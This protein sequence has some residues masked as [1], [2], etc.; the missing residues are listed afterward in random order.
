[1]FDG[2]DPKD[3]ENWYRR[4]FESD[5]YEDF[6]LEALGPQLSSEQVSRILYW[7]EVRPPASI[8]DLSCGAG[9]HT[10]ELARRGF[11]A[12][13][14]DLSPYQLAKARSRSAVP[15]GTPNRPGGQADFVRGDMRSIPL[16]DRSVQAVVCL[17]N[18]FGYFSD[19]G[20]SSVL[21]EVRRVLA[22]GG[23]LV[24]DVLNR[25][26]FLLH[27]PERT[28]DRVADGLVLQDL[29]YQVRSG[30]LQTS[31]TY[32]RD[33]GCRDTLITLNRLYSAHELIA[34]CEAAGL[35]VLDFNDGQ[36]RG[37]FNWRNSHGLGVVARRSDP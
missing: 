37:Y 1:M 35:E 7:L 14:L 36:L 32:I 18:S 3:I 26:A 13:G 9:R 11:R 33:D 17:F 6:N 34:L 10:L 12:I 29:E 22:P 23:R 2:Q 4:Y 24:L 5:D 25:D 31:W 20:N 21:R 30:R 19:E 16:H 27:Q 8:L 28:W 15:H